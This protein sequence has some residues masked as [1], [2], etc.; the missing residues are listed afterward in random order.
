MP[1]SEV[2]QL[3]QMTRDALAAK[4]HATDAMVS[5]RLQDN[6]RQWETQVREHFN[7]AAVASSSAANSP[8]QKWPSLAQQVH[9]HTCLSLSLSV[10]TAV[11]Y[12]V[13]SLSRSL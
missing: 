12:A 6:S 8:E 3:L 4:N 1:W 7:T 11:S 10:G 2:E 9:T 5:Q 13:I